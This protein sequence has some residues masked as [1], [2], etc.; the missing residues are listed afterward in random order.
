MVGKCNGKTSD[1]KRHCESTFSRGEHLQNGPVTS[2]KTGLT[3]KNKHCSQCFNESIKDLIP[4]RLEIDCL[5]LADFNFVSSYSE[6]ISL[7][8][9]Q[10]CN[11]FYAVS[12][13]EYI[14]FYVQSTKP[15]TLISECNVTGYWD[16]YRVDLLEA[17]LRTPKSSITTPFKNYY[18][19]LC[20]RYSTIE[21]SKYLD[22][23]MNISEMMIPINDERYFKFEFHIEALDIRFIKDKIINDI[24]LKMSL[25]RK[26]VRNL[27]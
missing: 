8:T 6:I 9:E 11:I 7:A 2:R 23:K 25:K 1:R 20:N 3:Y 10:K 14:L 19:Y 4:W 12:D 16:R 5:N 18:C 26:K 13:T 24:H 17:C 22:T 21:S 27:Q 15:T